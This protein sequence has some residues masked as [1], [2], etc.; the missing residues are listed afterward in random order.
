[1]S[2]PPKFS[3]P[4]PGPEHAVLA[5]DV[6]TWD[7]ELTIRMG[8]AAQ[9]SRGVQVCRLVCGGLWL[10]V[11]F[12][13]ETTG[14]DG[15]GVFGYDPQKKKYVGTWVDPMRTFL[16]PMDGTWD[17]ATKTMS[18]VVHHVG[19]QGP[20]EWREVTESV[21]EKTRVCRT[22]MAPPG[23]AEV[24]VMTATYRRRG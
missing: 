5:R 22:F 1:M 24:E 8:G 20:M 21:D 15:H 9:E 18:Y 11:D 7:A 12:V 17:A 2:D 13:N 10:V 4:A 6:G 23:V 19:P 14:F 16:A 3:P